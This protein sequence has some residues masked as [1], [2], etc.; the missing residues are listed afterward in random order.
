MHLFHSI[1]YT[2]KLKLYTVFLP[3][4]PP[5][6]YSSTH[7]IINVFI[8][9]VSQFLVFNTH[10]LSVPMWNVTIYTDQLLLRN[11][12]YIPVLLTCVT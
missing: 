8:F 5:P 7:P 11:T 10:Y 2:S 1:V 3:F 6:K 12:S 4:P 9:I